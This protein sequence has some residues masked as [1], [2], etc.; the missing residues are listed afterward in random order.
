M[1]YRNEIGKFNGQPFH[2]QPKSLEQVIGRP[3]KGWEE[4]AD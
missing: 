3:V 2:S 1:S 4:E